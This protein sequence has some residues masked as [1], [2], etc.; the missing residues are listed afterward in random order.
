MTHVS[1]T[2]WKK[3]FEE[4]VLRAERGEVIT[5]TRR[6]RPIFDV[7]KHRGTIGSAKFD[8]S[9]LIQKSRP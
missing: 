8:V 6:G 2:E 5:I 4:L 3:R 7:V 9:G 1:V